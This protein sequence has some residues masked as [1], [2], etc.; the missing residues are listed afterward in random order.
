MPQNAARPSRIK[1]KNNSSLTSASLSCAF[2]AVLS[3]SYVGTIQLILYSLSCKAASLPCA[4]ILS[5]LKDPQFPNSIRMTLE[6][7]SVYVLFLSKICRLRVRIE[8]GALLLL[9]VLPVAPV[10]CHC[11]HRQR[12][13]SWRPWSR[14]SWCRSTS[15]TLRWVI[16]FEDGI[17]NKFRNGS[18]SSLRVDTFPFMQNITLFLSPASLNVHLL[19]QQG[20]AFPDSQNASCDRVTESLFGKLSQSLFSR[21][22][23]LF[24]YFFWNFS[25]VVHQSRIK[26]DPPRFALILLGKQSRC[27]RERVPRFIAQR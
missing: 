20:L 16:R 12:C 24:S 11:C 25:S 23:V 15:D 8:G 22:F 9:A 2:F 21:I 26:G 13:Q 6:S 7:K 19:V 3:S 4:V 27:P 14:Y 5:V 10:C 1:H 18:S 17:T